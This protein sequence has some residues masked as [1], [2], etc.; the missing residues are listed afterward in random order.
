MIGRVV[1]LVVVFGRVVLFLVG[2]VFVLFGRGG[3][4]GR[5]MPAAG[6]RRETCGFRDMAARDQE[7]QRS[8]RDLF[9]AGVR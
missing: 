2:L 3:G 7:K 1:F 9:A 8:T 4:D 5:V 6:A